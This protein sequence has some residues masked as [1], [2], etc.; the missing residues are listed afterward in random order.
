MLQVGNWETPKWKRGPHGQQRGAVPHP[1]PMTSGDRWWSR[2]GRDS[3]GR[4]EA[5][6]Q[7]LSRASQK[8][9]DSLCGLRLHHPPR[10]RPRRAAVTCAGPW[11]LGQLHRGAC[12]WLA[13][14]CHMIV[15]EPIA[16][17]GVAILV[18]SGPSCVGT[19]E[20]RSQRSSCL[21]HCEAMVI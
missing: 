8:T 5:T 9:T 15:T 19:E 12:Q 18:Q 14:L 2:V 16:G 17:W 11:P 1:H 20:G 10:K 4:L 13:G 21:P 7:T 3:P 6:G